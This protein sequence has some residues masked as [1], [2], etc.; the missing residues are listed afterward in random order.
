[1]LLD[2]SYYDYDY[3]K[4]SERYVAS[5][6]AVKSDAELEEKLIRMGFGGALRQRRKQMSAEE[7]QAV[8][9][10]EEQEKENNKKQRITTDE[11]N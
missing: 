11:K 8:A 9:M 4:P 5:R 1:M 6:S 3:R 7:I 2:K 10:A